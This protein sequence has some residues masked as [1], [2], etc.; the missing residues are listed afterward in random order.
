MGSARTDTHPVL[1]IIRVGVLTMGKVYPH[2]VLQS[3]IKDISK[4]EEWPHICAEG[5]C[6]GPF[7]FSS[8]E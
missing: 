5:A 4:R 7:R 2:C 8:T 3:K 6:V 1:S